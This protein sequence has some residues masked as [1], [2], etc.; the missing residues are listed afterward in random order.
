MKKTVRFLS[1]AAMVV[2]LLSLLA[3]MV[4]VLAQVPLASAIYGVDKEILKENFSFPI[5]HFLGT[6]G[7]CLIAVLLFI[8]AVKESKGFW[9][10]L[11]S[12]VLILAVIPFVQN[13]ISGM[14]TS[15]IGQLRGVVAIS[16]FSAVNSLCGMSQS[17]RGLAVGIC[18]V[19]C[20]MRIVLNRV[21]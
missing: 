19:T 11:L 17:L 7:Y 9:V 3:L 14:E 2:L 1:L 12:I 6:G 10:E 16:A 20:G 21:K 5:S 13:F 8:T 4:C 18:L 15:L